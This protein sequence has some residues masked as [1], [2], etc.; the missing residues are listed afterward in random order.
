MTLI[1]PGKK[2]LATKTQ[3]PE[4]LNERQ[5]KAVEYVRENGRITNREYRQLTGV[6]RVYA[7]SELNDMVGKGFLLKLGKGRS[8]YSI[9]VSDS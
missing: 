1:G 9:E 6:S 3:I 8:V 7:L 2:W 5:K 4:G